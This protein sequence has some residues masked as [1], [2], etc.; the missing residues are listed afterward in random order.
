MGSANLLLFRLLQPLVGLSVS[1]LRLL[2]PGGG[3]S[4]SAVRIVEVAFCGFERGRSLPPSA[5]LL[6]KLVKGLLA[7]TVF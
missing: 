1:A 3:L 6:T 7:T 5:C 4:D 2:Q